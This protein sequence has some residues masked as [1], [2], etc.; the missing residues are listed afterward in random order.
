M[1]SVFSS[2]IKKSAKGGQWTKGIFFLSYVRKKEEKSGV[3]NEQFA[4]KRPKM[5]ENERLRGATSKLLKKIQ[6]KG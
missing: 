3:A 6:K 2:F 4:Q 5:R 1:Q